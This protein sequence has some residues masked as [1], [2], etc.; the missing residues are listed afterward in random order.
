MRTKAIS[1]S[2]GGDDLSK[3]ML[4][5]SGSRVGW[6]AKAWTVSEANISAEVN[7]RPVD[8]AGRNG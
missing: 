2:V 1:G 4:L 7:V 8:T 5:I 3:L 6:A